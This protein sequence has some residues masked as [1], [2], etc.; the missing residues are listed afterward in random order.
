MKKQMLTLALSLLSFSGAMWAHLDIAALD[1]FAQEQNYGPIRDVVYAAHNLP[2]PDQQRLMSWMRNKSEEGHAPIMYFYV[3]GLK[4]GNFAN[5]SEQVIIEALKYMYICLVRIWQDE[6]CVTGLQPGRVYKLFRKRF[7]SKLFAELEVSSLMRQA[8]LG[9]ARAWF[10]TRMS[11]S[12]LPDP[13]WVVFC[14]DRTTFSWHMTFNL[15]DQAMVS[16]LFKPFLLAATNPRRVA[17]EDHF[18]RGCFNFMA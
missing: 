11:Y 8:A 9:Q 14:E 5:F 17:A 18:K 12:D 10:E 4:K 1:T 16:K 3:R 6:S 13:Y 7:G 2:I 15:V